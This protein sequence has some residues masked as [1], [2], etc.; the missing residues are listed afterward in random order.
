VR[1]AA[2]AEPD[3]SA[4]LGTVN[5]VLLDWFG[6]RR[7]F[8]TAAYATLT[9]RDGTWDVA[10]ASAGHPSGVVRRADGSVEEL[11]GGGR[12]LGLT[13]AH[14]VGLD[15]LR[16]DRGDALVLDTDGITEARN[17]DGEQL[18]EEGVVRALAEVPSDTKGDDLADVLADAVVDAAHRHTRQ[19][20]ADDI[21]VV[22]LGPR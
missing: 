9:P 13:A 1:T 18:D 21:A 6:A 7:S 4:V 11:A 10:V 17:A 14:P 2:H 12:V 19:T 3:P 15:T 8:V 22:A 20:N 5:D 16:L